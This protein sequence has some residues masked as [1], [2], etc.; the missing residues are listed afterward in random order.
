MAVLGQN[1]SN[2]FP[3]G[4]LARTPLWSLQRSFGPLVEC[5]GYSGHTRRQSAFRCFTSPPSQGKKTY[6]VFYR[7]AHGVSVGR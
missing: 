7:G 2:R 6:S 4:A 1:A 5:K 3:V